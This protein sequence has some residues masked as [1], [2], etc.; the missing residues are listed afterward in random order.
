MS[1]SEREKH[2]ALVDAKLLAAVYLELK[3]GRER[4]LELTT[5]AMITA[6]AAATRNAYGARPRPL[7]LRSTEEERQIHASFIRDAVKNEDLWKKHGLE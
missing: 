1:L 3:G 7:A 4:R 2:G 6:V 5:A